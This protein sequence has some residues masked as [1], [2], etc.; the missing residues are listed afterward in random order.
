MFNNNYK[1]GSIR[2]FIENIDKVNSWCADGRLLILDTFYIHN[3]ILL[4]N[5]NKLNIIIMLLNIIIITS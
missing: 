4:I 3:D 5:V 2:I 1:S